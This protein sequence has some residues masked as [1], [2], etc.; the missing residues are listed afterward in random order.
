MV[1]FSRLTDIVTCNLTELLRTQENP[2][3]AIRQIVREIEEG[4]SGAERSIK[5]A[6]AN[7]ERL[8]REIDEQRR[9]IE[10][11]TTKARESL[12]AGDEQAARQALMRKQEVA[13]LVDGLVQ[14]HQA[15]VTTREHLTTT[16]RAL[17]ARLAEARRKMHQIETGQAEET[18][19]GPLAEASESAET[20]QSR[21]QQVEAELEAL[22]RE[23][24][25]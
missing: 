5:T 15:A 1:Y 10:F 8:Q 23:L 4:I 11:W 17:R 19:A 24:G 20:W 13:D 9:Q 2:N 6:R 3:A 22:K 7:E 14:Q 21:A 16:L 25:R 18:A 12:S